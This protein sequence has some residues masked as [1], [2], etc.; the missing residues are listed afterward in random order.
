MIF[1][2][3]NRLVPHPGIA[4]IFLS[5]A[6]NFLVLPLYKRADAMQVEEREYFNKYDHKIGEEPKA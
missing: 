3:T 2:V 5:L 6:V 1:A 4:I